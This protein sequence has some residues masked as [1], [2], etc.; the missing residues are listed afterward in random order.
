MTDSIVAIGGA[1]RAYKAGYALKGEAAPLEIS[2]GKTSFAD[3]LEETAVNTVNTIRAG[4]ATAIRAIGGEATI[5]QAVEATLNME[6]AV[7]TTV[8]VRDKIIEAYQEVL[9]MSV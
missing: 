3:L 6:T 4:D 2:S 7:R 9:R 5:Q 8:A 1:S